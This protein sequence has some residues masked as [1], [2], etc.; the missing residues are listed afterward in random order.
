MSLSLI[1]KTQLKLR[2]GWSAQILDN[3]ASMAEA[4]IYI[5][6]RL[7][8]TVVGGR[9]ALVRT[10]IDWSAFNCRAEWLKQKLADYAKWKDYNNAD[11]IGEGYPPRDS[12]GDPYELHHIGQHQNSP[13][14]ELTW[15]EHMGDGNNTIL[16]QSGK[17]SEI[18]RA[19][20]EQEKSHHWQSR[21]KMFGKAELTQIY[22]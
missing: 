16:H 14:A 4:E 1:E 8:E 18:D 19:L 2:T 21:F 3:I 5:K 9:P 6:A 10:D 17:E 11:L 15:A 13:F 12:N 22:K 7:K 20:F